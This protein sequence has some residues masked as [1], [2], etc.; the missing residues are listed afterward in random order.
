MH[1]CALGDWVDL[2]ACG[3]LVA[4][5]FLV[6]SHFGGENPFHTIMSMHFGPWPLT[7]YLTL[8]SHPSQLPTPPLCQAITFGCHVAHMHGLTLFLATLELH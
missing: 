6:W 7:T 5:I 1:A 3:A 4:Y 2:G 8:E